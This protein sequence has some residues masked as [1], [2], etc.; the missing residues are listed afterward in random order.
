MTEL[1]NQR[2]EPATRPGGAQHEQRP[3]ADDTRQRPPGTRVDC[4]IGAQKR[5]IEVARDDTR[6]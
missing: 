6:N 4:A 1:L 5:S 2:A 3:G